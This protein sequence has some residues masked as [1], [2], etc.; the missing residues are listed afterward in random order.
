MKKPHLHSFQDLEKIFS[1]TSNPEKQSQSFTDGL[2]SKSAESTK[3]NSEPTATKTTQNNSIC[4]NQSWENLNLKH[5]NLNDNKN[6][7]REKE[8]ELKILEA[9]LL[10]EKRGLYQNIKLLQAEVLK[11]QNQNSA[12]ANQLAH[13]ELRLKEHENKNHQRK[14]ELD[15]REKSIK[16]R[17][18][19]L[20]DSEQN[21]R[22]RAA[23]IDKRE[24]IYTEFDQKL[25][26]LEEDKALLKEV[27]D[28][29]EKK[30]YELAET[31]RMQK[32]AIQLARSNSEKLKLKITQVRKNHRDELR[33]LQRVIDTAKIE[34]E[35]LRPIQKKYI[36][37]SAKHKE[38]KK[39]IYK[40]ES[41][42][43]TTEDLSFC[44][45]QIGQFHLTN[46]TIIE[47]L[48]SNDDETSFSIPRHVT[49]LGEGPIC[50]YE[51]IG[52]LESL[53]CKSWLN[54]NEWIIIGREDWCPERIDA[55]I[56]ERSN[57]SIRIVSQEMFLSAIISGKDPFEAG[58][59]L[60]FS[61][62]EGHPALEYIIKSSFDWP[63]FYNS[64]TG[65]GEPLDI[66]S[67]EK[68]P[69]NLMG[70][71]VGMHGLK[72]KNRRKILS[73]AYLG[74]IPWVESDAYM[75]QWGRAQTRMRLRRMAE[76]IAML[77]RKA[78]GK[79]NMDEA[80]SDW[81]SDLNWLYD[82]FYGPGGMGFTWP[83]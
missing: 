23:S 22:L 14:S 42:S 5:I 75:R 47:W 80:I 18:K 59:D 60:L 81:E 76:H 70:Y 30:I 78:S 17:E 82:E 65:S 41:A 43:S 7:L 73:D 53:N 19:T 77:I 57:E 9:Q 20:I 27:L 71:K 55:L 54:G 13:E 3:E 31:E 35:Q 1:S 24:A 40:L 36:A 11:A 49:I 26:E 34:L 56:A 68:S 72:E 64:T 74:D 21:L 67:V 66:L 69:L 48:L 83:L 61:F 32:E 52:H 44:L 12:R 6:N 39:L 8:N 45:S 2:D 46:P 28:E 4:S 15:R 16:E 63:F 10:T 62:A 51:W 58:N 38:A 37:L 50:N 29:Q 25:A 33:N 79:Y